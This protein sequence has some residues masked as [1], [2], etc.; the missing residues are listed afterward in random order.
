MRSAI[1]TQ[2]CLMDPEKGVVVYLHMQLNRVVIE[3]SKYAQGT[4]NAADDSSSP[5]PHAI[6]SRIV[7]SDISTSSSG[8]PSC[9]WIRASGTQ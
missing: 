4:P 8:H 2:S 7:D 3:E 1:S 6:S 9:S 5:H